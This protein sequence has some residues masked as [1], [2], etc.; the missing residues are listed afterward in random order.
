MSTRASILLGLLGL[1]IVGTGPAAAQS[2]DVDANEELWSRIDAALDESL[3]E[4]VDDLVDMMDGSDFDD[5]QHLERPLDPGEGQMAI[6]A[7]GHD[8]PLLDRECKRQAMR[9]AIET[10]ART[11]GLSPEDAAKMAREHSESRK[12]ALEEG[13]SYLEYLQHVAECK[14]FCGPLVKYMIGCHVGAVASRQPEIAFFAV[15]SDE[16]GDPRSLQAVGRIAEELR[17]A[18]KQVLLIGRASKFG[19]KLYNRTL[20]GRRAESVKSMLLRR[21]V[22]EGRIHLLVFGYEPPQID[23]PIAEAYGWQ[24]EYRDLGNRRMNQSVVMVVF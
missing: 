4:Q 14:A 16:I 20:S 23:P 10:L 8:N 7:T 9:R 12:H 22:D 18:S 11:E 2:P 13:M 6:P 19:P 3:D 24:R 1:V 5:R 15:D 21:G 17:D